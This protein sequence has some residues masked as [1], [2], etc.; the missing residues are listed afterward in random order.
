MVDYIER[1]QEALKT[2]QF[3]TTQVPE[4][5]LS[6]LKDGSW[7]VRNPSPGTLDAKEFEYFPVFVEAARP[8]G[9]QTEFKEIE[10]M[11]RGFIKA[12][13]ALAAA[14]SKDGI[15]VEDEKF[16]KIRKTERQLSLE[17]LKE[18]KPD[19]FKKVEKKELSVHQA[20]IEAGI[21]KQSVKLQKSPEGFVKYIHDHFTSKQ[22]ELI[23]KM[24]KKK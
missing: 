3:R 23:I 1:A 10:N 9:L 24:L 15:T 5:I 8:W 11:C 21:R 7:K 6:I 19:L 16:K 13:L 22:R 14:K 18:D 2:H 17:R 20:M 12:E 4:L